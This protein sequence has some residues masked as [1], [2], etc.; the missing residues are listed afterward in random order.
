MHTKAYLQPVG[1]CAMSAIALASEHACAVLNGS[2]A[3]GTD[4]MAFQ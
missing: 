2:E 1:V 4:P 3:I